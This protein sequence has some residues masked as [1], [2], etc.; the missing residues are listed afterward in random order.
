MGLSSPSPSFPI[1]SPS[2][3]LPAGYLSTPSVMSNSSV[4]TFVTP[5]G[6]RLI[7]SNV[8]PDAMDTGFGV[9]Y[10]SLIAAVPPTNIAALRGIV[11]DLLRLKTTILHGTPS[12]A[13]IKYFHTQLREHLEL[14]TPVLLRLMK[15]SKVT[16]SATD[17]S[18]EGW[19][20]GLG[21][22]GTPNTW[23]TSSAA[24]LVQDVLIN[25]FSSHNQ[26]ALE[27]ARV[28]IAAGRKVG[29]IETC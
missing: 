15:T 4:S 19:T 21:I 26:R 5:S 7:M 28:S 23:S 11:E 17:Y 3:G 20:L 6:T 8:N 16:C 22:T 10:S 1:P 25:I 12:L 18:G 24:W 29:Q 13:R 2:L 27:A 9:S 14:T